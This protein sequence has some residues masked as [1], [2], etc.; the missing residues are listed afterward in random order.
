MG[1]PPSQRQLRVGEVVR[2]VLADIF[3]RHALQDPA[4]QG[5]D[6]TVSEVRVS[7]DM[8]QATVF[9]ARLGGGEMGDILKALARARGFLRARIGEALTTK[10]TPELHFE[11]DRSFDEAQHIADILHSPEVARDLQ[12]KDDPEADDGSA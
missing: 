12:S 1:K 2:H 8:R 4:L 6:L 9:V 7:P 3:L 5:A 10:F 11:I